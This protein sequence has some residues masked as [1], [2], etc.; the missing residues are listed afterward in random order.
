[1]VSL[2]KFSLRSTVSVIML[3]LMAIVVNILV[4]IMA[5]SCYWK[6]IKFAGILTSHTH[7]VKVNSKIPRFIDLY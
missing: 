5:I 3:F 4:S 2:P 6:S 7:K 1:M